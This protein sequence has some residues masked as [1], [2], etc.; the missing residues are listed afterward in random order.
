MFSPK[1]GEWC[2]VA[3][4]WRGVVDVPKLPVT[5]LSFKKERKVNFEYRY[6]WLYG[7]SC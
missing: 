5:P 2:E 7:L 4:D 6:D 1:K 3:G